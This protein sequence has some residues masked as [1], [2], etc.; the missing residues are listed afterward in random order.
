MVATARA[1]QPGRARCP[2]SSSTDARRA[3]SLVTDVYYTVEGHEDITRSQAIA[4][5]RRAA[6]TGPLTEQ[7]WIQLRQLL[8]VL[9]AADSGVAIAQAAVQQWPGCVLG[10]YVLANWT[11]MSGYPAARQ[12]IA[13]MVERFPSDPVALGGAGALYARMGNYP[14][15]ATFFK[16]ALAVDSLVI[17]RNPPLQALYDEAARHDQSLP[18]LHKRNP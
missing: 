7:S 2:D 1:Q 15:A 12:R 9:N 10:H 3:D 13:E 4:M 6:T 8:M 14:I 5:L 11:V 18:Q 17:A 16:R